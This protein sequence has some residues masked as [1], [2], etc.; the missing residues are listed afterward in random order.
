MCVRVKLCCKLCCKT[1]IDKKGQKMHIPVLLKK[2]SCIC[3]SV[4]QVWG[5]HS[6]QFEKVIFTASCP[7]CAVTVP[8]QRTQWICSVHRPVGSVEQCESSKACAFSSCALEIYDDT[9]QN[10]KTKGIGRSF[11]NAPLINSE[12]QTKILLTSSVIFFCGLAFLM[13]VI[14]PTLYS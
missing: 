8:R 11:T 1:A 10:K 5:S 9:E 12:K 2:C 3:L 14:L 13:K 6:S 7:F 4:G